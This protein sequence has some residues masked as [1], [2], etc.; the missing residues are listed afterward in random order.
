MEDLIKAL[1]ILAKYANLDDKWPTCCEHDEFHVYADIELEDVS[2]EDI[3]TLDDLGFIPGD[4][5][6]ISYRFGSC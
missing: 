2:A 5:G 4:E 6:F 1:Q 3:V